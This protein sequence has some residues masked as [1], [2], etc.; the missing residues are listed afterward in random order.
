MFSHQFNNNLKKFQSQV[1]YSIN[2]NNIVIHIRISLKVSVC[3]LIIFCYTFEAFCVIFIPVSEV[4][5]HFRLRHDVHLHSNQK[6]KFASVFTL[7]LKDV[8]TNQSV[9]ISTHSC[10][11][12]IGSQKL[13][14]NLMDRRTHYL[15]LR[16][17]STSI[18]AINVLKLGTEP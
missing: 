17:L 3:F 9:C 5:L 11:M 15:Y 13:R 16:N 1:Q 12:I 14:F 10:Q 8:N 18:C 4:Q 7:R 2:T 6:Q